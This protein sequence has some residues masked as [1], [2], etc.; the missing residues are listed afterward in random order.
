LAST[1]GAA[2]LGPLVGGNLLNPRGLCFPHATRDALLPKKRKILS[3]SGGSSMTGVTVNAVNYNWVL[4]S[5]SFWSNLNS[6]FTN[7]PAPLPPGNLDH[8]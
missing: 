3:A 7:S 8:R 4:A 6:Q 1:R 5:P 2:D